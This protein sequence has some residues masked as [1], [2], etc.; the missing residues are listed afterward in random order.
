MFLRA[1]PCPTLNTT[2]VADFICI[3]WTETAVDS[4][5]SARGG[6]SVFQTYQA[7]VVEGNWRYCTR[8]R[9]FT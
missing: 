8:T 9:V 2:F 4:L 1:C 3:Q 6:L 7:A 5:A